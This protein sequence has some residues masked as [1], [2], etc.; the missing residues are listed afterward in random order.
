MR[1]FS[2]IAGI[3]LL[4]AAANG[5]VPAFQAK[6]RRVFL[7]STISNEQADLKS[8]QS[9]AFIEPDMDAFAAGFA[10]VFQEL[11]FKLCTPLSGTVPDDLK[12][13]Y[14]QNGPAMFSA[15]SIVPPKTSIVQPRHPPVPDGQDPSRMVLHPLEGD[16]AVLGVTFSDDN[17]V[18]A[19][20]RYVRTIAFT[21]ERKKGA[22]V[23]TGME[24]T[25]QMGPAAGAGL[26]ND[27][28]LPLFRHHFQ[29]GLN[30]YRKNTSNTR[31]IYWGK[32]LLTMSEGSQ[33]YKLDGLALQ[34]EGRSQLGGAIEREADPFGS[35]MAYDPK[36]ERAVFYGVKPGTKN[37]EVT[38][39]EFNSDFRLVEEGRYTFDLPGFAFINDFCITENY[40]VFVLPSVAVKGGLL[41]SKDPGKMI[42]I[43]EGR[44]AVVAL[45]PRAGKSKKSLITS[46][47]VDAFTDANLQ[48]VNAFE[49]GNLVVFDAIR[50]DGTSLTEGQPPAWP[51]CNS[52]TQ[53]Q[54][55]ASKKS[56]WRYTVDTQTGSVSKKALFDNHCLFGTVN[57]AFSTQQYKYAYVAVGAVGSQAAPPQGI[58]KVDV[59]SGESSIWMAAPHEFCGEPMYAERDGADA[60][61]EDS[62]YI[63]SVLFNGVKKESELIILAANDVLAGPICRFPLGI[64]VPHGLFGC[65][66]RAQEAR[67]S[68]D[69]IERRAKLLDKMESRGNMWNEVKSDFSGLG[70]RF[71]DM[72]EYFGDFFS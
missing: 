33:P 62:G 31:A 72:E 46:I 24:S 54:S 52:L 49:D 30:K 35:K 63:L 41:G 53:Y 51:W 6:N 5:L 8:T 10:T 19:R 32:R 47:P 70:L 48:F 26:G 37:S 43:D 34:S 65:F 39:Y 21:A 16:G 25:R 68:A 23:Y 57:P 11:S 44:E 42:S 61:S 69:S 1:K 38:I 64:A 36:S 7:A 13:T 55:I 71:D 45:V 17:Q 14:F 3:S 12:G 2:E 9:S 60:L 4:A 56:L 29:P 58:A 18:V 50:S 59:S 20:Y 28:P 67:W 40:S 66:T 27:F 22:K 15:G